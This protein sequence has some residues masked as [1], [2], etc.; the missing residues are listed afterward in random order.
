[1]HGATMGRMS[2]SPCAGWSA[3]AWTLDWKTLYLAPNDAV[4]T[5]PGRSVCSCCLRTVPQITVTLLY[6]SAVL[7][8]RARQVV[9][10]RP[11]SHIGGD[12]AL[13]ESYSNYLC[14]GFRYMGIIRTQTQNKMCVNTGSHTRYP[15]VICMLLEL[16]SWAPRGRRKRAQQ[17]E[18]ASSCNTPA[19]LALV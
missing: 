3:A 5:A 18:Y 6:Q 14:C 13:C 4:L 17:R 1:M 8:L 16:T 9:P 2:S 10:V 15:R 11:H 7:R 19:T 12:I